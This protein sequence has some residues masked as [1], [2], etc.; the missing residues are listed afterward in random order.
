MNLE[1]NEESIVVA[2]KDSALS[3]LVLANQLQRRRLQ[4][5]IAGTIVDAIDALRGVVGV[6]R[7]LVALVRPAQ[8]A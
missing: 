2:G 7:Q 6:P 8:R 1:T 5:S 4:S 3:H